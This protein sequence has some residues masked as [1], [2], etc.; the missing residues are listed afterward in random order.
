MHLQV[1]K[2]TRHRCTGNLCSGLR[3]QDTVVEMGEGVGGSAN[4]M[5]RELSCCRVD[6]GSVGR[7]GIYEMIFIP[8][9]RAARM[10]RAPPLGMSETALPCVQTGPLQRRR[11]PLSRGCEQAWALG[12][13]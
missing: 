12:D 8:P 2:L 11:E 9:G 4:E 10:V 1:F 6:G 5:S 7:S 13:G 3:S